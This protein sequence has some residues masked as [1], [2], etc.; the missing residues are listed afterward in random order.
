[1]NQLTYNKLLKEKKQG[2]KFSRNDLD[3]NTL[4]QLS[5]VENVIDNNIAELFNLTKNQVK[6]LRQKYNLGNIFLKRMIDQPNYIIERAK[7]S[8][9]D[10]SDISD[11]NFQKLFYQSLETYAKSRNWNLNTLKQYLNQYKIENTIEL[12]NLELEFDVIISNKKHY[13]SKIKKGKITKGRKINQNKSNKNK[14]ISGKIGEKIVYDYEVKKVKQLGI[15]KEVIW[16]TKTKDKDITLDGL[17][18]DIVSYNKNG[19]KIYIE[20]KCS[21]TNNSDNVSFNISKKEIQLMQGKLNNIDV[22]HCFI[23]YVSKI[24]T[25]YLIAEI[26]IIDSKMFN[27]FKL[28]PIAY[29]VTEIFK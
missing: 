20:V 3:Y 24:D 28:N 1:M 7:K 19:E 10:F 6:Y 14:I 26:T 4:Y 15:D 17:G 21:T 29:E 16:I 27:N 9:F 5:I 8:N 13:D 18:Y 11:E 25:K 2:K 22:N 23:Y 12:A